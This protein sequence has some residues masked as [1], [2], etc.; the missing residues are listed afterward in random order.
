MNVHLELT[1]DEALLVKEMLDGRWQELLKEI[2]HTDHREFRDLLKAR[3][4]SLE[5]VLA[6]LEVASQSR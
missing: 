5:H 1:E 2:R 3:V 4:A 6:Q